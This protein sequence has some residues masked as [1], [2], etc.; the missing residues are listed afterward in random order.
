MFERATLDPPLALFLT[1][2][3]GQQW[4]RHGRCRIA[5]LVDACMRS[6]RVGYARC[7]VN[8]W[9]INCPASF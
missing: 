1:K 2:H 9:K 4:L 3:A 7:G 6:E 8:A 5:G